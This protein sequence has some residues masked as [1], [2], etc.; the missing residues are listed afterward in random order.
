M[1]TT[2]S[3]AYANVVRSLRAHGRACACKEC[4]L[5]T[6]QQY[7]PNRFDGGE[8]VRFRFDRVGY[9][10][11]MNEFEAAVGL[12][13]LT[14]YAEIVQKRH[15]NLMRG[16]AGLRAFAPHLA[17]I[18]EAAHEFIGP[19]ALPIV[20]QE[21]AGF[22]R[23]DLA[24]YLEEHGVE[25]RTLFASMPTQCKGYAYLGYKLGQFPV[26]EYMGRHGLHIGIHQDLGPAEIDYALEVI[27]RFIGERQR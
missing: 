7:C 16:L 24:A 5:S 22:S 21:G 9:S 19:H 2:N 13:N 18:E 25:T 15:D 17:T 6:A 3:S 12:G 26:A 20:V 4:R 27:G 10:C 1:V 11:K 23:D 8:D 14:V